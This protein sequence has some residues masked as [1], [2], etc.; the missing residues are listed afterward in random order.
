[1]ALI[2]DLQKGSI[3]KRASAFL[4]DVILLAIVA[5]GFACL[6][7]VI[8]GYDNYS[9][10]YIEGIEKYRKQYNV[11][12]EITQ[13]QYQ[14]FSPEE[15]ANWDNAYNALISDMEVVKAYNVMT[16]MIVTITSVSIFLSYMALEFV[17]P[18]ILK[19]G[20]TVGKKVFGLAV[21]R[22]NGVQLTAVPLFIRT[23]LGKY[24]I[25]TMIP[26]LVLIMILFNIIGIIG[27]LLVLILGIVQLVLVITTKTNSMLHDLLSDSVVVDMSSQLIFK[28]EEELIEYKTKIAAEKAAKSTY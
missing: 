20:Q 8:F 3:V 15:K 11:N 24:V 17:V 9:D 23:F 18:C 26:V 1:M 13:Q 28:T 14:A 12:F 16:T 21:M 25:E 27:P 5:V 19:D 2:Y 10:S 7:S 6:L 4:L 22:T